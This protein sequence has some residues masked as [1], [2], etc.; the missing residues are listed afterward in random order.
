M[1]LSAPQRALLLEIESDPALTGHFDILCA[2]VEAALGSVA[3]DPERT[4]PFGIAAIVDE[5]PEPIELDEAAVVISVA[6]LE[7]VAQAVE[8]EGGALSAAS[9]DKDGIPTFV[10]TRPIFEIAKAC[11]FTEGHV[12][13]AFSR[14]HQGERTA[15]RRAMKILASLGK[16]RPEKRRAQFRGRDRVV[17]LKPCFA[18]GFDRD[19]IAR[20]K[21]GSI[22]YSLVA[23]NDGYEAVRVRKTNVFLMEDAAGATADVVGGENVDVMDGFSVPL[24]PCEELHATA[25]AQFVQF[26]DEERADGSRYT[27]QRLVHRATAA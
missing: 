26:L 6:W 9:F 27:Y 23:R 13:L 25:L 7:T 5:R 10:D 21:A 15:R 1:D 3:E 14:V 22:F 4:N 20:A 18:R 24:V 16:L 17:R 19:E 2:A 12:R 11:G 8:V